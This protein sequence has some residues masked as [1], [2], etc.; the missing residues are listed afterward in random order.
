M[1]PKAK[2]AGAKRGRP[3]AAAASPEKKKARSSEAKVDPQLKA[4]ME[5][6]EL[7]TEFP[8][9][10]RKMV[11]AALPDSLAVVSTE[12]VSCQQMMVKIAGEIVESVEK[13][14]LSEA[15]AAA[16]ALTEIHGSKGVLEQKAEEAK[17]SSEAASNVVT[18]KNTAVTTSGVALFDAKHALS[19]RQKEQKAGEVASVQNVKDLAVYE[20]AVEKELVLLRDGSW[21][22]KPEAVAAE[23]I[24]MKL[25]TS[26]KL[27]DSLMMVAPKAIQKKPAER[28]EFDNIAVKTIEEGL[29]SRVA[30]LKKLVAEA[31]SDAAAKV[32]AVAAAQAA[33]D[34]TAE[35]KEKAGAEL[36]DA[37]AAAKEAAASAKSAK[38]A[39][40][41]HESAVEA[42]Q[43]DKEAKD[44]SAAQF[45]SHN[46]EC[47]AALRDKVAA[48]EPAAAE[49]EEHGKKAGEGHGH[50]GEGHAHGGGH[51]HKEAGHDGDCCK[52]GHGHAGEGHAGGHGSGHP[53]EGHGHGS[54]HK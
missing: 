38:A 28:G 39:V 1:A 27:D 31:E 36:K 7:A 53:S 34:S 29:V 14:L 52:D 49:E 46:V 15:V 32:A 4:V 19:E 12:R 5:A 43:H 23:K 42:A 3:A 41:G 8:E 24:V 20:G 13:R 44:A 51:A 2:A 22:S 21:E 40:E 54:G 35:A 25:V 33:A 47:F 30:E 48:P 6:V 16:A 18:E 9:D 17:N 26:C 10:C 37:K 50:A 11:L 45:K